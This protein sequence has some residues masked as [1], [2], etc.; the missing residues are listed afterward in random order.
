[1]YVC[2]SRRP[3][4]DYRLDVK[5]RV[6]RYWAS[7]GIDVG[8]ELT[9][10]YGADLW[11]EEAKD[12]DDECQCVSAQTHHHKEE[13]CHESEQVRADGDADKDDERIGGFEALFHEE[14]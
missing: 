10:Y 8:D 6:I 1:M 12:G 7:R 2:T 4:I 11:F 13:E 5:H 3:N 9:I 14:D